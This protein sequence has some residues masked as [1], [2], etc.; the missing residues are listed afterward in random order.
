VGA[1]AGGDRRYQGGKFCRSGINC[2]EA[3]PPDEEKT[4]D[5]LGF[6]GWHGVC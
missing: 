5:L 4:A 2:R 1:N 6:S 3:K